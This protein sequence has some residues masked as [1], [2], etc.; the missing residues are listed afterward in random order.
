METYM[1][2]VGVQN[3]RIQR[4][5]RQLRSGL[6]SILTLYRH[7]VIKISLEVAV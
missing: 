4:R 1:G 3:Q 7:L 2:F 5:G 6:L